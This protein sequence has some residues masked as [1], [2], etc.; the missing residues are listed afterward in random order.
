MSVFTV[1]AA[2]ATVGL[3]SLLAGCA[4]GRHPARLATA[5]P[6]G[7]AQFESYCAACHDVGGQGVAGEAPPLTG[8]SWVIGPQHRLIRILLH[9]VRG[10]IEVAGNTY[11]REMPGFGQVMTDAEIASLASFVRSQFGGMSGPVEPAA[12]GRIRAATPQRR[13]PWTTDELLEDR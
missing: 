2:A 1:A 5:D 12:I 7:R 3:A 9:G 8:S 11:N 10:P 4:A 6:P 13:D